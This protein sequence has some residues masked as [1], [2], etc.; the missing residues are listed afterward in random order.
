MRTLAS[1][2]K[3]EHTGFELRNDVAYVSS[4]NIPLALVLRIKTWGSGERQGGPGKL[5]V[6]LHGAAVAVEGVRGVRFWMGQAQG[7]RIC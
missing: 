5:G 6:G 4:K 3:W 7:Y 2:L 1:T